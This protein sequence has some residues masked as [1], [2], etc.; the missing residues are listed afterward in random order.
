MIFYNRPERFSS[1]FAKK[2]EVKKVLPISFLW[3]DIFKFGAS[4]HTA[5][6]SKSFQPQKGED[7]WN[8]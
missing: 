4:G 7:T 1:L 8:S 3:Y 6:L 5:R 2:A